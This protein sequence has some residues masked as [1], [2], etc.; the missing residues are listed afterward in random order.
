MAYIRDPQAYTAK[1]DRWYTRGA[2]LYS[3]LV[4]L[5][6]IWRR[7]IGQAVPH[8]DGSN[9]LEVSFGT[10]HLFQLY[11]TDSQIFGVEYNRKMLGIAKRKVNQ[12]SARISL[13]QGD[14]HRLPYKSEVFDTVVNTMA[15]SGY[16][17]GK[18]AIAEINRVLKPGGKL[19]MVDINYPHD[20]NRLGVCL[21]RL[22]IACGDIIRDMDRL[23][24]QGGFHYT[25]TQIGGWGSVHLYVATKMH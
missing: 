23:F 20:S 14:V 5:V 25:D 9:V 17:D 11:Q 7:W 6:P 8:A 21:T 15:F 13:Q 1:W 16:P 12:A 22:W 18:T 19:V 10:G 3:L 24:S 2:S 4:T